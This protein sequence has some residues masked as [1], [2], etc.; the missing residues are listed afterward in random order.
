MTARINLTVLAAPLFAAAL[1]AAACGGSAATP[2]STPGSPAPPATGLDKQVPLKGIPQPAKLNL[3]P[4]SPATIL[5]DS[6]NVKATAEVVAL[7][8]AAGM[9]PEVV[10]ALVLPVS[11]TD[12]SLLVLRF[13]EATSAALPDESEGLIEALINSPA[14]KAAN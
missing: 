10:Q 12:K 14:A 2:D 7:L 11:G 5:G 6:P 3:P 9:G 13:D 1:I 4:D 8:K